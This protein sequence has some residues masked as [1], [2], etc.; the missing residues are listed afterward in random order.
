MPRRRP[1]RELWRTIR[2]Q[3][4]ERDQG[5]CQYPYG[6]HPVSLQEAHID[7]IQSG[8]LGSNDLSNLRV[9]CHYHAMAVRVE[10]SLQRIGKN[11]V[12]SGTK[13]ESSQRTLPM[14]APL[15]DEVR[16]HL[17]RLEAERAD[18]GAARSRTSP[19]STARRST[20]RWRI[21]SSATTSPPMP[22]H[23]STSTFGR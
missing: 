7:H 5:R 10:G 15:A 14:P 23:A 8:K 9:L 1:S 19:R 16:R 21:P 2:R 11:L 6:T 22:S 13:T 17:Q 18:A 4:W 3:V 12:R 20:R